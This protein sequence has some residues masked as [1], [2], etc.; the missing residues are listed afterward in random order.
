MAGG[1]NFIWIPLL[2]TCIVQA[3]DNKHVKNCKSSILYTVS[4]QRIE[5]KYLKP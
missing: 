1:S 5:W 3:S 4:E 2:L